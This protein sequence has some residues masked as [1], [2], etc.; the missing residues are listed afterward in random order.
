MTVAGAAPG[1]RTPVSDFICR[2][3][4]QMVGTHRVVVWYDA[5][6][7]F[8]GLLERLKRPDWLAVSA[9]TSTLRARR[10]A[11]AAYRDLD[12]PEAA[13]SGRRCLLVYVPAARGTTP[14]EQQIDPFEAFARCG[15]A[16]GDN[17]AE[18]LSTLATMA[19]PAHETEIARLFREGRPTIALLDTLQT[20]ARSPLV[21]QALGTE[22][23]GEAAT[24]DGTRAR[25]HH[26]ARWQ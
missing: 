16:F 10:D 18:Q 24:G 1:T 9:A 4:A 14:E 12:A 15:A 21:R 19:L 11:D 7:A 23:A 20:G 8:G 2:R 6:Q 26:D 13:A 3:I 5:E 25:S 22:F 17:E